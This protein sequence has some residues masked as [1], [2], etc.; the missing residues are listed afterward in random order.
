M[1][2]FFSF[3]KNNSTL[4]SRVYLD[5]AGATPLSARAEK[6][7]IDTLRVFGNASSI[8]KEGVLARE[9]LLASRASIARILSARPHEIYF[10]GTGTE[11]V[12]LALSGVVETWK[13]EKGSVPHV[14]TSAIEHPAV[15]EYLR[16]EEKAGNIE[17]TEVSVDE[18]GLIKLSSI[19]E[20][21]R[22]NTALVTIMYVSNELGTLMPIKE[23]GRFLREYKEEKSLMY[24][25]FHTDAC[26]ASNHFSLHV[27][28]LRVDLMSVNS[29]KLYGPKGIAFLYKREGVI[30]EPTLLG[31]G[32][33]RGLRSG[34]EAVPLIVSFKEA[35]IEAD[36]LREGEKER[37]MKM[38]I[39][40]K[41][42][43]LKLIP[44]ATFY[45]SFKEGE[46]APHIINC[47]VPGVASDEMILRLD[48]KG[49]AVSHKSACAS[50]DE[51]M[52]YVVKALGVSDKEAMENIRITLGRPTAEKDLQNLALAM[53]QISQQYRKG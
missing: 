4:S 44:E 19:K 32:Q 36:E 33:E 23:I 42:E 31:G 5:Y 39:L 6:A 2:R 18:K 27:S 48:A 41:N 28:S 50:E 7:L 1:K 16:T 11:S 53:S 25:L 46:C 38:K 22:E 35:L 47:R 30:L 14:V 3:R 24:P 43:L 8:Y 20:S 34:T 9:S 26:Q 15:R 13:K 12:A 37:L 21:L 49:F 45:G 52:S 17:L 40:F 29:S 10:T 51:S